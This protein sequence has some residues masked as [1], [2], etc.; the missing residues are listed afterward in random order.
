MVRLS[1]QP[2][3]LVYYE[4]FKSK[5]HK[6]KRGIIKSSHNVMCWQ[7]KLDANFADH[8]FKILGYQ[9]VPLRRDWNSK[10]V[11]KIVISW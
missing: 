7:D 1:K 5:N 3:D 11:G 6:S 8:Q 9:F 10:G 4:F 2:F